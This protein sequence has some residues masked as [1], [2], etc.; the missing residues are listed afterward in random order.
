[1]IP[2]F[3]KKDAVSLD[4]FTISSNYLSETELMDNAGRGIAQFIIE[5]I[6]NPF[7]QKFIVIAGPGNNGGDATICHHYLHHYGV[8]SKL[9]LFSKTQKKSWIFEKYSI[10]N[11]Y[12]EFFSNKFNLDPEAWYIDGIFGIGLKRNITGDYKNIIDRL[13]DFQQNISIEILFPNL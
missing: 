2:V 4:E 11:D 7:N 6:L 3:S 13:L 5:N 1:M 10:D 12:I 8:S 9:L